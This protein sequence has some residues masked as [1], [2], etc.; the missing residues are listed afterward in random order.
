M[1]LNTKDFEDVRTFKVK[2][3]GLTPYF[4]NKLDIN[5]VHNKTQETRVKNFDPKKKAEKALYKNKKGV[6]VPERH[7]KSPLVKSATDFKWEG[8]KTY[9]DL[10]RASVFIEPEEIP[11]KAKWRVD[12]RPEWVR[13]GVAKVPK[14]TA[15]PRFDKWSLEFKLIVLDSRIPEETLREILNGA[16]LRYGCGEMHARGFGKFMVKEFKKI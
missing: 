3:V 16:G 9:K 2:I 1:K 5:E 6:F 13:T 10:I 4:Q 7:I 8:K 11:F 12:I 15:R 14:P